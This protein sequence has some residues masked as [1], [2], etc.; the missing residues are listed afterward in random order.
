MK[1]I[2][3]CVVSVLSAA[4]VACSGSD[5]SLVGVVPP[6]T[7][8]QPSASPSHVGVAPGPSAPG[9]DNSAQ[10]STSIQPAPSPDATPTPS[11]LGTTT[12]RAYFILDGPVGS[13]GLV[14][15]LREI[16]ATKAVARAA[17]NALLAGPNADERGGSHSMT[18]AIP[19]GTRL[20]GLSI[21]DG[22]ATVDLSGEF[23]VIGGSGSEIGRLGQ[24]VF[25][26]T[27]FS[28]VD[29]VAFRVDGRAGDRVR[30]RGHRPRLASRPRRQQRSRE[31]DVRERPARDLRRRTGLGR[32]PGQSRSGHGYRE[33]V[34]G[35]APG[36]PLRRVGSAALREPRH[37]NVRHGLPRDVRRNRPLPSRERSM[38]NSTRLRRGRER[39]DGRRQS[40][41]PG[42]AHAWINGR[43]RTH[44]WLLKTAARRT[45]TEAAR[46]ASHEPGWPLRRNRSG[47]WGRALVRAG[48]SRRCR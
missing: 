26:L 23:E 2:L 1:S 29:S 40:R 42:V 44:L 3:I 30:Q 19:D 12:V 33:Y 5:G 13:A 47:R 36:Q 25:T 11:P 18:S 38:G 43:A 24:V 32:D 46:R 9:A 41:V 15:V 48:W 20:L 7:S 39:R 35:L 10:P 27:Q 16:P 28:T 6:A 21:E 34:R 4:L 8:A 22:V 14:P 17:M 45:A 37:G 31:V